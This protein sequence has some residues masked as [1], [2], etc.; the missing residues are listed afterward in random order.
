MVILFLCIAGISSA[1]ISGINIILNLWYQLSNKFL[2]IIRPTKSFVTD[3]TNITNVEVHA[4]QH[5][6]HWVKHVRSSTSDVT[7]VVIATEV[8]PGIPVTFAFQSFNAR[9]L[10]I[11]S[12]IN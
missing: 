3:Q 8:S 6:Q 9:F 10:K 11:V 4:K 2:Q 1:Y 5:A 12:I 7:T